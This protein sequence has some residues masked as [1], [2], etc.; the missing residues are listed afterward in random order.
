MAEREMDTRIRLLCARVVA[1]QGE[2]FGKAMCDLVTE[3]QE[4]LLIEHKEQQKDRAS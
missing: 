1:A 3:I 2:S 4:Y